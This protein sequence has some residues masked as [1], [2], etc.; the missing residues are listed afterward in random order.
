MRSEAVADLGSP[1]R[2]FTHP[3]LLLSEC[4]VHVLSCLLVFRRI[5]TPPLGDVQAT[6]LTSVC[7][8]KFC[9]TDNGHIWKSLMPPEATAEVTE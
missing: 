6:L 9:G 2:H 8:R 7:L 5:H 4:H 3:Q 1:R